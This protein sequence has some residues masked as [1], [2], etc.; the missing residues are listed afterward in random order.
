MTIPDSVTFLNEYVF[1]SCTGLKVVI[2]ENGNT[3]ISDKTIQYCSEYLLFRVPAADCAVAKRA[4]GQGY[5]VEVYE[6]D[7]SK[8]KVALKTTSYTYD[9]KAKKPAVTVKYGDK[10]LK[11]GTD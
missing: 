3:G 2:F 4:K 10:A 7:L 5:R 6:L 9:G 8:A 1:E 11:E